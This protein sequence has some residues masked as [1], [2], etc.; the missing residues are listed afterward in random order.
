MLNGPLTCLKSE[1]SEK[2]LLKSVC[3]DMGRKFSQMRLEPFLQVQFFKKNGEKKKKTVL[4]S[5]FGY[6]YDV[7]LNMHCYIDI[8]YIDRNHSGFTYVMQKLHVYEA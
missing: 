7:L 8:T 5:L 1:N 2:F 6:L 4:M 3:A